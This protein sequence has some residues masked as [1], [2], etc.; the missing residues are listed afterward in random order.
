MCSAACA[1]GVGSAPYGSASEGVTS[2]RSRARMKVDVVASVV[3][4]ETGSSGSC[5]GLWRSRRFLWKVALIRR[6]FAR[7]I[8]HPEPP[9]REQS[10]PS[11][12]HPLPPS[13]RRHLIRVGSAW[14]TR[15]T[16]A[17]DDPS[18]PGHLQDLRRRAA[19]FA[20]RL[21]RRLDLLRC[22]APLHGQQRR[23]RTPPAASPNRPAWPAAPA[24]GRSP[25]RNARVRA[26]PRPDRGPPAPPP[27]RARRSPRPG[28][29]CVAA[30]ARPA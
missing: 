17:V 25:R 7:W 10:P 14:A 19:L 3:S 12:E 18:G 6:V 28:R 30:A 20:Q 2:L 8:T 1:R 4:R 23:R 26:A 21:G 27:A 24:R 9:R 5:S 22:R 29:W 16:V 15:T 11:R 13:S